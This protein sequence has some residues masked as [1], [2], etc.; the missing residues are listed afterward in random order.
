MRQKL[1]LQPGGAPSVGNAT[2]SVEKL[3]EIFGLR[4]RNDVI[5]GHGMG[6]SGFLAA[7]LAAW[8]CVSGYFGVIRDIVRP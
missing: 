2:N 3:A 5:A 6:S 7:C 8:G 4:G 1:D